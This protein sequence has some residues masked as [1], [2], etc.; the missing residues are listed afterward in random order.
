MRG[1]PFEDGE[2]PK[3]HGRADDAFASVVFDEAF[4]RAAEIHEPTAA[5]RMLAAAQA[6]AERES[7]E[8]PP[9]EEA[10][11]LGLTS[12][13]HF[14]LGWGFSEA[15]R[16]ESLDEPR[17][18]G[19]PDDSYDGNAGF[20]DER[21]YREY[22]A[23]Q[24]FRDSEDTPGYGGGQV[25]W[26]RPVAWVLAVVMGVGVVAMAFASLHRGGSSAERDDPNPPP[27]T[28]EVD[29]GLGDARVVSRLE[30]SGE[31]TS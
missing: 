23:Y 15:E 16:Q 31:A 10:H 27:A 19:H 11:D 9:T 30:P 21:D 22:A 2:D 3:E 8:P 13:G 18:G 5:E 25:R 28:S 6:R 17:F 12:P 29:K 24:E 26:Y 20:R 4:V 7:E 14:R 1:Q